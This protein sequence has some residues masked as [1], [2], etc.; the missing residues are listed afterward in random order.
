MATINKNNTTSKLNVRISV[1]ICFYADR[2]ANVMALVQRSKNPREK[3][4]LLLEIDFPTERGRHV[5]FQK[6]A[7]N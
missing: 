2:H 4:L 1:S 5:I 6:P 7:R 3:I